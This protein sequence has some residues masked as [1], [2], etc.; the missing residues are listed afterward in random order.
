MIRYIFIL[1]TLGYVYCFGQQIDKRQSKIIWQGSSLTGKHTGTVGIKSG[2]FLVKD[3]NIKGGKVLIDLTTITC[4]DIKNKVYN[5]KLVDH[6]KSKDFFE[7]SN[8][9]TCKFEI[10]N[11][12]NSQMSGKLTIKG[13]TENITIP[14][15]KSIE[16]KVLK[17][18]GTIDIDRTK[19]N[20]IYGS[21][22]F[23]K[24][25]GDKMIKDN[26]KV[27]FDIVAR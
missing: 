18:S 21:G 2:G 26:F 5:K 1:V 19:F 10:S 11:V 9:P 6:L 27:K 17:L 4:S 12:I 23:F 13:H 22:S 20:I 8:Y 3:G 14:I 24:S 15:K 25:L 7:V 16:N